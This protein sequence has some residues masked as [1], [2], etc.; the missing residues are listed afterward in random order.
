MTSTQASVIHRCTILK[1]AGSLGVEIQPILYIRSCMDYT[2]EPSYG[3]AVK[4]III[5]GIYI[6]SYEHVM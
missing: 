1:C 5:K 4:E 6:F 2:G 3:G